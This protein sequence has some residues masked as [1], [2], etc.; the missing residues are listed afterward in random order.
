LGPAAANVSDEQLML[1][2]ERFSHH[3]TNTAGT[4]KSRKGHQQ[5]A[6]QWE[7]QSH[8][9]ERNSNR[10]F[11][12]GKS[13]LRSPVLP[14]SAIRHTQAEHMRHEWHEHVDRDYE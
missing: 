10:L 5:V 9:S 11:T 6:E 14:K 12:V 1:N 4:G 8:H 3:R 2:C 13:A 7:Q